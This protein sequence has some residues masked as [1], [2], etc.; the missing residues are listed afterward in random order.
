M[1]EPVL[2]VA[3]QL[4]LITARSGVTCLLKQRSDPLTQY[5]TTTYSIEKWASSAINSNQEPNASLHGHLGVPS[6]ALREALCQ[7]AVGPDHAESSSARRHL[8]VRHPV[9]RPNILLE[10]DGVGCYCCGTC[11]R[12]LGFSFNCTLRNLSA[13]CMQLR[14]ASHAS[15]QM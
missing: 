5:I 12:W 15:R 11:S 7:G 13:N 10:S 6:V 8:H 14:C 4:P 9:S 2:K 3:M 1:L